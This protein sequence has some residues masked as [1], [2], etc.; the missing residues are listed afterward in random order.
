MAAAAGNGEVC[1][2]TRTANMAFSFNA[3]EIAASY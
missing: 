3:K 1:P 2:I